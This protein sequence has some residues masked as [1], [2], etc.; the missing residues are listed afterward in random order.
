MDA[1]AAVPFPPRALWRARLQ[2]LTHITVS[3]GTSSVCLPMATSA[4]VGFVAAGGTGVIGVLAARS[5]LIRRSVRR[6][7][8]LPTAS[9]RIGSDVSVA[10][11]N[12]VG[13]QSKTETSSAP[14]MVPQSPGPARMA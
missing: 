8:R 14:G 4:G 9:D 13:N 6:L 10:G 3:A 12:S 11:N 2:S 1:I 7:L 5:R